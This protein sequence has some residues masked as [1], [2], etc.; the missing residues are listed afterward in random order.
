M[1]ARLILHRY[2]LLSREHER[3]AA[4]LAAADETRRAAVEKT[5]QKH[6]ERARRMRDECAAPHPSGV[7]VRKVSSDSEARSG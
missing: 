2:S 4:L 1:Q 5:K 6:T 7:E 3:T